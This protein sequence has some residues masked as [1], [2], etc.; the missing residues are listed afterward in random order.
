MISN[1]IDLTQ[2]RD[3]GNRRFRLPMLFRI[4]EF[5]DGIADQDDPL[6]TE[7]EYEK[8][9]WYEGIFGR[10]RHFSEKHR[11]FNYE[12]KHEEMWRRMCVRCGARLI[13]WNN[14]YGGV[15][16]ACESD[17]H[18]IPWK[19]YYGQPSGRERVTNDLFNL[20]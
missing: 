2:N 10:R 5:V 18:R 4:R 12:T 13:P 14:I 6:V 19:D 16:D 1:R 20:R 7:E 8:L 17:M 15:C 3:F 11:V 9:V